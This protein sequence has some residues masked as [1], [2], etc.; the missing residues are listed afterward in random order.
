VKPEG[1]DT[2]D[3]NDLQGFVTAYNRVGIQ[4]NYA[5]DMRNVQ[6]STEGF[7]LQRRYGTKHR[8]SSYPTTNIVANTA[9]NVVN[10]FTLFDPVT[11]T[12]YDFIVALDSLGVTHVYVYDGSWIEL[13]TIYTCQINGATSYTAGTPPVSGFSTVTTNNETQ[14]G[15]SLA[16]GWP[17]GGFPGDMSFYIAVNTDVGNTATIVS[18][19]NGAHSLVMLGVNTT[20]GGMNWATGNHLTLYRTDGLLNASWTGSLSATPHIRWM[21]NE[22]QRKATMYNG[23]VSGTQITPGLPLQLMKRPQRQYGWPDATPSHSYLTIPV[24]VGDSWFTESGGGLSTFWAK[25]GTKAWPINIALTANFDTKDAAPSGSINLYPANSWLRIAINATGSGAGP[26]NLYVGSYLYMTLLYDGYEESDPVAEYFL[27]MYGAGTGIQTITNM[28]INPASMPKNVTGCKWYSGQWAMYGTA[29]DPAVTNFRSIFPD[30]S[31]TTVKTIYFQQYNTTGLPGGDV[32][33]GNS[34]AEPKGRWM[35]YV[36]TYTTGN[37]QE[38]SD[39]IF[40]NLNHPLVEKRTLITPRFATKASRRQSSIVAVDTDDKTLRVSLFDGYGVHQ[41]D[42]APFTSNC[43]DGTP[44]IVNLTAHG[45][46]LG[47]GTSR[48]YLIALKTAEL[49]LVDLQAFNQE[50]VPAD[51]V[52]GRSILSTPY[53]LF[54]AGSNNIYMF[55]ISGGG[56]TPIS[57]L[58]KNKYDGTLFTTLRATNVAFINATARQNIIAGWDPTYEE[59]WFQI[60]VEIDQVSVAQEYL[61]YCYAPKTGKWRVVKLN[62]TGGQSAQLPVAFYSQHADKSMNIGYG[63][64]L[65][66]STGNGVL[67]YPARDGQRP[68]QDDVMITGGGSEVGD[69]NGFETDITLNIGSIYSITNLANVWDHFFDYV[70]SAVNNTDA[71]NLTVYANR[72]TAPIDN[73]TRTLTVNS[74]STRRMMRPR[75]PIESLRVKLQWPTGS[76]LNF[77][78]FDLSRISFGYTVKRRTGTK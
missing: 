41:D 43:N 8:Y 66:A 49:E 65:N 24:S 13:T 58:W 27:N 20:A 5:I 51:V 75:G 11:S 16:S 64:L 18:S 10:G 31:F 52:A 72:E 36:W 32:S 61:N 37:A 40:S 78:N 59:V 47:L 12:D 9:I 29:N 53:G 68:Y 63:S 76:L 26:A 57:E 54:W 67:L 35:Q 69:A 39:N 2:K 14:N 46:L 25:Y 50:L 23:S 55:P 19:G 45:K 33:L 60:K 56:I 74:R 38:G 62:F 77:K 42:N 4:D 7:M 48:G 73:L 21:D 15:Q 22:T 17:T 71:I 44:L 3:I 34:S 6:I 30:S 1:Y 28:Y 70:G